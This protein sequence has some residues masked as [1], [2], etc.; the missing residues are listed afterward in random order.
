[1][2]LFFKIFMWFLAAIALMVGL[3]VFLNWTSQTEP[4]GSRWQGS[5]RNQMNVF[6][7]TAAQ[8]YDGEGEKGL[9]EFLVNVDNVETVSHLEIIDK[10]GKPWI[11]DGGMTGNYQGVAQAAAISNSAELELSNTDTVLAAKTFMLGTGQ[12]YTL[13]IR[14]QRPPSTPFFGDG[15][16]RLLRYA[17][18]LLTALALCYALARY[19]SSPIGKLRKATQRFAGGELETRVPGRLGN[20]HDEL[21]ALAR[22]FDEMAERIESLVTSQ[23]RLTRDI[24]HELRSP[25]SRMNV[26]LEIAKQ[27]SGNGNS[28]VLERIE[29]ESQRLNEMISQILTLA[30]LESGTRDF[31]RNSVDLNWLLDQIVSDADYEAGAKGKAVK[32]VHADDC[33]TT[34]NENLLRSAIENVLRNAVRYT[35]EGT[36]VEVSLESVDDRAALRVRDFGGGVP[37]GEL[38]NLFRPFYRVGEARERKTGG[39]GLGLA[40]AEQ[41]VSAHRGTITAKNVENGLAIEI[42]IPCEVGAA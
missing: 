38:E 26:A 39:T 37:E 17:V 30:K 6:A 16:G 7:A 22:D 28:A 25:L 8:V 13:I 31:E 15:G 23:Q 35:Q 2:N 32:I 19:L 11:T 10:D 9:K 34:G 1:M 3:V 21:G 12:K 24:S 20:R 27:K 29:N 40:I 14:W 41:A 33:F 42:R 5:V 4:A 18:L 36:T